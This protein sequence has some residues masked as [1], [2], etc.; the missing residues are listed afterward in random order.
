MNF[1]LKS[2]QEP[3]G[4]FQLNFGTNSPWMKGIQISS[5]KGTSPLQRGG[6]H[7]NA[8]ICWVHLKILSI[9]TEPEKFIY[10]SFL[11]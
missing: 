2:S 8:I 10:G 5:N 3:A 7:K 11:T 6:N 1:F 4:Q 9:T